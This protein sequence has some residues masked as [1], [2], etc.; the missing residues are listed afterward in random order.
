MLSRGLHQTDKEGETLRGL[1]LHE[2]VVRISAPLDLADDAV[3]V[4]DRIVI[5]HRI[6]AGVSAVK[7]FSLSTLAETYPSTAVKAVVGVSR[8]LDRVEVPRCEEEW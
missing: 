4:S 3:L 6:V 2:P 5:L 8:F 7:H 1:R